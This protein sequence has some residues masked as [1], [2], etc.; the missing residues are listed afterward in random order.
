MAEALESLDSD[1]REVFASWYEE[2]VYG[3]MVDA[4]DDFRDHF[5]GIWDSE[6]EFAYN[7]VDE[8]GDERIKSAADT[9]YF[10]WDSYTRDL[11]FDFT[12]HDISG[13]RI[14]VTSPVY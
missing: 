6:K 9:G 12:S 2:G 13:Y 3:D 14:G 11:F 10:D 4:V 1:E 8:S 7:F 5:H